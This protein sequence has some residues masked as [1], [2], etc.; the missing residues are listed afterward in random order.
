M[1]VFMFAATGS[2]LAGKADV[3]DVAVVKT[4]AET[5]TFDVTVKHDDSGWDHFADKWEIIGPDNVVLG[6]RTLYHPHV[7]EQPFTRSLKNVSATA[8]VRQVSV[9]AHCSVH[10][11][12]GNETAVPLPH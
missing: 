2:V 9:K 6:T 4:G 8:T 3:L 11:Y 12:G 7:D 10:G 1:I 5:F